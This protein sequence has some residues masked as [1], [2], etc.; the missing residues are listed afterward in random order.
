MEGLCGLGEG[1]RLLSPARQLKILQSLAR[2]ASQF[3]FNSLGG[4]TLRSFGDLSCLQKKNWK[5]AGERQNH[6]ADTSTH[7]GVLG[8]MLPRYLA[9]AWVDWVLCNYVDTVGAAV[10]YADTVHCAVEYADR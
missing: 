10:V 7:P 8:A 3:L 1:G 9:R 4:A 6:S 5:T 2:L